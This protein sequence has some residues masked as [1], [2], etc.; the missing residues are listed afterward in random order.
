MGGV[1]DR[2]AL[3]PQPTPG[4]TERAIGHP[5]AADDRIR[6]ICVVGDGGASEDGVDQAGAAQVRLGQIGSAEVCAAQVGARDV[7]AGAVEAG[8]GRVARQVAAADVGSLFQG[9]SARSPAGLGLGFGLP[10]LFALAIVVILLAP[11]FTAFVLVLAFPV[12]LMP[13]FALFGR[14]FQDRGQWASCDQGAKSGAARSRRAE[15]TGEPIEGLCVHGDPS[16]FGTDASWTKA[17]ADRMQAW[18]ARVRLHR[19]SQV[20]WMV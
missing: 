4:I 16:L 5:R 18:H 11:A 6:H 1:T 8:R 10:F 9:A 3:A 2:A 14:G 17:P 15:N 20:V 13:G 19:I 12:A 7:A